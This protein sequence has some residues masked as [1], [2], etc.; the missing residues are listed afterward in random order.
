MGVLVGA[1]GVKEHSAVDFDANWLG[2]EASFV[3]LRME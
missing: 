2:D 1:G 3:R